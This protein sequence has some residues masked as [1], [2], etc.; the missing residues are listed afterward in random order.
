MVVVSLLHRHKQ[1]HK[2]KKVHFFFLRGYVWYSSKCRDILRYS[3]TNKYVKNKCDLNYEAA[4]RCTVVVLLYELW[5]IKCVN[6]ALLFKVID[7]FKLL[8]CIAL[9]FRTDLS[10]CLG[11]LTCT[12]K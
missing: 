10:Q 6:D 11:T 7:M 3:S 8:I 2:K 4:S 9:L 5:L 1:F 12:S